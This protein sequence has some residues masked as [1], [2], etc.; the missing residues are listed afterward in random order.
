MAEYTGATTEFSRYDMTQ[1][2][3][4]SRARTPFQ[5]SCRPEVPKIAAQQDE[6][7]K[8]IT[9]TEEEELDAQQEDEVESDPSDSSDDNYQLIP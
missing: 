2:L 1:M 7:I 9:V 4:H 3:C 8:G 5:P 6:T